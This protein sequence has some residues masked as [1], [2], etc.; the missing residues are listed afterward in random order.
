MKAIRTLRLHNFLLPLL[1]C[2]CVS[3]HRESQKMPPE[4]KEQPMERVT[5]IGGVFFKAHDPKS[6]AAWYAEHLSVQA[7]HGY[8]DFTWREKD[9]PDQVGHTAWAIFPTNATHFGPSSSSLMINYRVSNL[10]RILEQLRRAGISV[11]KVEDYNYGRFAWIMD[12]ECNRVELWEPKE[13]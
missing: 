2:G 3:E 8:A 7:N 13:K 12:P 9:H 1:A 4:K 11:E 10:D 5:G 6:Q